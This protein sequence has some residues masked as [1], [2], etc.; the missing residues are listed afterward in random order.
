MIEVKGAPARAGLAF[1][2]LAALA[3]AGCASSGTAGQ[4]TPPGQGGLRIV[5]STTGLAAAASV[6]S[7]SI[8]ITNLDAAFATSTQ[9]SS[10]SGSWSGTFSAIPTGRYA[11]SATARDAGRAVLYQTP[12]GYPAT[13]ALVTAN[14]TTAVTLVLQ[15]IAPPAPLSNAAPFIVTLQASRAETDLSTPVTLMAEAADPDPA[16]TITYAWTDGG[17]GGTFGAPAAPRTTWTP[18]ANGTARIR[19]TV[20]DPHG[21]SA[22]VELAVSVSDASGRGALVTTVALDR[23]PQVLELSS[24]NAQ[25]TVGSPMTLSALATDPDGDPLAFTWSA[26]CAGAFDPV[27]GTT[28][29]EG[30]GIRST[31]TFTPASPAAGTCTVTA[32]VDDGRGGHNYGTL[33]VQVAAVNV[34]LGPQVRIAALTPAEVEPEQPAQVSVVAEDGQAHPAW[35]YAWDDGLFGPQRGSFATAGGDAASQRYTPAACSAL[36]GGDHAITLAATVTDPATGLA[37]TATVPLVLH[38]APGSGAPVA[39]KILAINDFHGQISTGQKIGTAAVGGAGVLA[40]WLEQAGVRSANT[41][42]VEAGDLVGA[43]PASS[44]LLQDEPTVS[45]MNLFANASCP[46]MLP[47]ASQSQ[48]VDRFDALLDPA[49]NLVGIPGNHEFDEGVDELMRLLAGGNHAKGPFLQDPW[50]GARFPLV[51]ANIWRAD[52]ELLFRPY[53]IK[54][55]AGLPIAFVGATLTSTPSIVIPAGVAGLTFG[56]DADG[57]NAQVHKLKA[58]GVHAFVAV[59][60]DGAYTQTG[61]TG[62]TDATKPGPSADLV[63]LVARLDAD[64]DVVVGAHTHWFTNALL[65]NAGGKDVLCVQAYNAGKDYAD[66]DLTVDPAT[67]EILTKTAQIVATY[68]SSVTPDPDALLLATTAEA[69]VGPIAGQVVTTTTSAASRTQTAAGESPLGDL[70]AEAHRVA[71]QADFGITNPGGLRAD[72]PVSCAAGGCSITW[73]DCFTAQPFSNQVM[74]ITLT[75]QQL[76]DLLEQ[77]WSGCNGQTATR[78]LQISGFTYAWSAAATTCGT[79]VVPGSL[80]KKDGTPV[81]PAATY[82]VAANNFLTGGGDGFSTFKGGTALTPGPVDLDALIAYLRALPAPIAPATDGRIVRQ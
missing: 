16:D 38:C 82:T 53:V 25:G 65:K 80:K 31:T 39:V 59:I 11:I 73:N 45:F 71:M 42:L 54:V 8:S 46:A 27:A 75:G 50:G 70:V 56:D 20:T 55:V 33:A 24:P 66:I 68:A 58:L 64:V 41:L 36:G 26:D 13:P 22:W 14:G 77:Q 35:T 17:A 4:Q 7:V 6:A 78:M 48:G 28:V 1:V 52:G 62:P 74:K 3:A 69:R 61:Y 76:Q 79:R 37:N 57:I 51:S 23:A 19:L 10:S 18:A 47:P 60:H 2:L 44:A 34:A 72:L 15:E 43:S 49:C 32:Q 5:A 81:D 30:A 29:A 9:L 12:A 21:A 40:A 63:G 67:G